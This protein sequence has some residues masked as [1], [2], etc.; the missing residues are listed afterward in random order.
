MRTGQ[1][2]QRCQPTTFSKLYVSVE[3]VANHDGAFGVEIMS[4][5]TTRYEMKIIRVCRLVHA[6]NCTK[7]GR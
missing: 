7:R 5:I 2:E 6:D 4:T 3:P 1:D